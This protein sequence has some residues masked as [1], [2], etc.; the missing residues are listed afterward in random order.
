MK[1]ILIQ[2]GV[3]LAVVATTAGGVA[4]TGGAATGTASPQNKQYC[5]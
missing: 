5:C 1:K 2:L 3:A 4:V